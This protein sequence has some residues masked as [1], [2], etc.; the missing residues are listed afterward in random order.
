VL[1]RTGSSKGSDLGGMYKSMPKTA[2]LCIVGA[3]S[4][5][6]FPLFSGFVSKSLVMSAMLGEGHNVLWLMLLFASAGV[7]HHA[8]IKI[9]YFAFF[10]HDAGIRTAEAPRNMLLAMGLAAFLCIFIGSQPQYL[11]ALLPWEVDYWPYTTTHVLAQ[12]QLLFFAALA[13]VWLNKQ[14]IYPPELHAV[15]IDAEWLYRRL[16]P[17]GG[18]LVHGA[19]QRSMHVLSGVR[20]FY[21]RHVI[22]AYCRTT[23]A[24]YHLEGSWP[25]GNMVLWIAVVLGSYLLLDTVF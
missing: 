7:F 5:S 13:F 23:L 1:Y 6:A 8:G 10:A 21:R 18:R 24:D 17:A 3:A 25:T 22:S 15:N 9:P 4:I 16:L 12:M 2:L 20:Q 14:G 19:L 11:Y